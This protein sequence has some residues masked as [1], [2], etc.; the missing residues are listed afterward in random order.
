MIGR[1]KLRTVLSFGLVLLIN[2]S[3]ITVCQA[4]DMK[5]CPMACCHHGQ[6]QNQSSAKNNC[7]SYQNKTQERF[8]IPSFSSNGNEEGLFAIIPT[9]G[10]DRIEKNIPFQSVRIDPSPPLTILYQVFRL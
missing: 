1:F 6:G 4:M 5:N 9:I 10:Y 2:F 3:A 7:C 8:G